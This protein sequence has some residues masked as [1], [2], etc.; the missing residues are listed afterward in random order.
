MLDLNFIRKNPEIVQ[1][2]I[3]NKKRNKGLDI[4]D[5]LKLDQEKIKLDQ[6]LQVLYQQRNQYAKKKNIEKW[7]EIK[8]DISKLEPQVKEISRQLTELLLRVPNIPLEDVPVWKDES[9][10]IILKTVWDAPDFDFQPKSHEEIWKNLGIINTEKASEVAWSRFNYLVGDGAMLEYAL[11]NYAISLLTDQ[12]I[13]DNIIRKNWLNVSNK[14]FMPI[15][16]PNFINP[17]VFLKM[18]RLDPKEDRYY[19]ES[20]NLYLIWSAEHTLWPIHMNENIK[21]EDLPI[22]YFA[23]TSCYRKEAWTAGKDVRWILRQHQFDKVEMLSYSWSEESLEE[24]KLFMAIQEYLVESLGLPYQQVLL[25]TWDMWVPNA[26]HVDIEIRLPWQN[27]YRETHSADYNTDYQSRRL[28]IK[29]NI[30]GKK[31]FVHM[32]DWTAYALWRM[33]I[34]ILENYQQKDWSV[35]IPKVLQPYMKKTKIEKKK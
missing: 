6:Q 12:K 17:D 29:T 11:A 25:C 14:P 21:A 20:E 16:P 8:A 26:R 18:A 28:N 32:N 10:N 5:I 30:D 3:V 31:Q 34:A 23:N 19:I 4:Y 15:V 7:S 9:E 22:R 24:H 27:K 33:I 1:S 35:N 2:A 13:I